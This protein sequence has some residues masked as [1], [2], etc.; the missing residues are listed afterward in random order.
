M[1]EKKKGFPRHLPKM[2]ER[3]VWCYMT[4]RNPSRPII[5]KRLLLGWKV[6]VVHCEGN[7]HFWQFL[8]K[9]VK[10]P[11]LPQQVDEHQPVLWPLPHIWVNS[12]DMLPTRLRPGRPDYQGVG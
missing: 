2:A 5:A 11:G 3:Q 1:G 6:V 9:Q 10:I 4:P 7:E 12:R 8:Q